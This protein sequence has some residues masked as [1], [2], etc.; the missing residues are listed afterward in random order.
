ML[1]ISIIVVEAKN[2]RDSYEEYDLVIIGG[3]LA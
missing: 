3:G 1:I 2:L